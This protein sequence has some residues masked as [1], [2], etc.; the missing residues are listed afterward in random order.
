MIL[1]SKSSVAAGMYTRTS[2]IFRRNNQMKR[3]GWILVLLMAA[4]PAWAAKRVTVQQLTD[5]LVSMQ[6]HNKTD[7]DVDNQ[8]KEIELNEELTD[9]AANSLINYLPDQLSRERV[10]F[11]KRQSAFLAPPATDIPSIPAPDA[12]AQQAI[13]AKA[14]DFASKIY[15]QNPHLSVTKTTL[16]FEDQ[17]I[18]TNSIGLQNTNLLLSPVQ[19]VNTQVDT[20]ETEKGVE[21]AA[22]SRAK[23]KWGENGRISE[24]EPGTNLGAIFLEAS[25]SGKIGWLRWQMIDGWQT[26]VFSFAVEK[27]KSHFDVSYC[28]ILKATTVTSG[29]GPL[30]GFILPNS[31]WEPFKK[32][33]GY[34]G[35]FYINPN[36]G[37][38]VRVI[39]RAEMKP[40]DF[41]LRE[42]RRIDYSSVVFAGKAYMLPRA[43]ITAMVAVPNGDSN[44]VTCTIR[45]TL[46]LSSYQNYKLVGAL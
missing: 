32:V 34:H 26:A 23:T 10:E 44:T 15:A 40:T 24:G 1:L 35:E 2:A 25:S 20:V 17:V 33:V 43:S 45:H 11:L 41:V 7:E 16:R 12:A 9:S 18:T 36:T 30:V 19:L 31:T 3:L 27:K 6:Q 21:K 22:V 5:L 46:F 8:L 29:M 13:L 42:D 37:L 4:S 38:V 14:A 39:T 28:C